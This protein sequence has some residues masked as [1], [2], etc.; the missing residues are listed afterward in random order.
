MS[1]RTQAFVNFYAAM[2]TL[3]TYTKLDAKAKEIASQKNIAVRFKVRGGPDG[4]VIFKDGAVKAVPYVEGMPTDIVM[5]CPSN[6]K[7]NELVDGK[8]QSVIPL[9]GFFKLSFMLNKES[10][11]NVLTKDMADIMRLKEFKNADEKKLSTL[12]AFNAM[13]A[14]IA[15]IGNVD[16][17]GRMSAARMPEGDIGLEIRGECSCTIR[18]AKTEDGTTLEYIDEAPLKSRSRMV[19][20]S[21]ETA[22]GVIDG[23]LDAMYCVST[24]KIAM[25]GFI[26]MLQNLNNILNIVPKYLS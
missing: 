9:K 2:G 1:T 16:E 7:F 20:D 18:V 13:V 10:A 17:L 11:F 21:I 12:L 15:Q 23:E 8:G 24:G 25:S 5:L 4:V 3:Q 6:E 19:F 26:P 14:A 22:K